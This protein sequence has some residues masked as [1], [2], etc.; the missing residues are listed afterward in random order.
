MEAKILVS[1]HNTR[2]FAEDCVGPK[3]QEAVA[4]KPVNKTAVKRLG[5]GRLTV[6]RSST[7]LP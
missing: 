3:A 4:K 5:R 2:A 6:Y 7:F 1:R